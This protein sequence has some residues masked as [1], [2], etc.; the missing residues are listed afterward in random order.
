LQISAIIGGMEMSGLGA[1]SAPGKRHTKPV[2]GLIG[3]M[4][5]GKTLVAAELAR[6]GGHVISG[7]QLGHEALRQPAI[8]DQ[9]KQRWGSEVIDGEGCV[10]RRKL[11]L[12]VFPDTRERKALEAL[13]FPFIERRITEEIAAVQQ[14]SA[15]AFIVLDAAIMLEAG[16]N[17]H[18]DRL[19]YV[20]APRPVRAQRLAKQR[21]WTE[22]DLEAREEAQWP[23][24][25]KKARAGFV[26]NNSGAPEKITEQVDHLLA[27]WR[28][29][30]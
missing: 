17:K 8:R 29:I 3:G 22:K 12:K 2:I 18:C 7:D 30:C 11:G 15:T 16:W 26:I 28:L 4:G 1:K 5:S 13:V 9:I 19:V 25:E 6:R 24:A 14:S 20:D 10:D 21:G 23:V 27:E